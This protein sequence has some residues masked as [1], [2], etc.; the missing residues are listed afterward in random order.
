MARIIKAPETIPHGFS[1]FLSGSIEMGAA[2]NW[3]QRMETSLSMF[4]ENIVILN[5]R[6]D[7]WDSSWV[8]DISDPKFKEQV[9]WEINAMANTHL[10]AM[11]FDPNTKSPITLLELGL[12][13]RMGERLV[14]CCPEGYWRRGNVQIVCSMF[15]IT[16]VET[17]DEL[18]A[19]TCIR[20]T[21]LLHR[22]GARK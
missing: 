5:P 1:V 15:E 9:E 11:Y 4:G 17:L 10:M 2:V 22:E 20:M 6:R 13:A 18:I 16:L 21:D 7:D 3:Q 14:V 8:Q 12:H 19:E